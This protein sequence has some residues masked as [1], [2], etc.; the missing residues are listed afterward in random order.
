MIMKLIDSNHHDNIYI[1]I[2]SYTRVCELHVDLRKLP[3]LKHDT[4]DDN[5]TTT[6]STTNH[7]THNDNIDNNDTNNK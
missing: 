3:L 6:T 5:T 4:N 1:Y 7:N 2:Y